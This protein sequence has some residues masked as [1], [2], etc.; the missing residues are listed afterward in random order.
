MHVHHQLQNCL[1]LFYLLTLQTL[2]ICSAKI[3]KKNLDTT[4][5][6]WLNTVCKISNFARNMAIKSL[7]KTVI[8]DH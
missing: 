3:I 7:K 8:T 2:G 4:L 5:P 6:A 1:P